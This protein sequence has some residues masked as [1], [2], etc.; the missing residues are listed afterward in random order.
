MDREDG[1]EAIELVEVGEESYVGGVLGVGVPTKIKKIFKQIYR[2]I[3]IIGVLI[4][5]GITFSYYFSIIADIHPSKLQGAIGFLGVVL[6]ICLIRKDY[7]SVEHDIFFKPILNI[8]DK[9]IKDLEKMF[10]KWFLAVI[11]T[12][13]GDNILRRTFHNNFLN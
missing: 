3:L 6:I 12:I 5:I 4:F 8:F 7:S 11:A 9:K 2:R 1:V 10:C 13:F